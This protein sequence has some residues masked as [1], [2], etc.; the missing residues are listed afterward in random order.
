MKKRDKEKSI[1]PRSSKRKEKL[2]Q[3]RKLKD[4]P[5]KNKKEKQLRLLPQQ[6]PKPK[7]KDKGKKS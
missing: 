1:W 3:P 2:P 6:L 4:L 5:E 7:L